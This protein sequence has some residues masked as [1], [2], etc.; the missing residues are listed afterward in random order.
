VRLSSVTTSF[1]ALGN[2][3]KVAKEHY[4]RVT[5]GD[6]AREAGQGEAPEEYAQHCSEPAVENS[7]KAFEI[8]GLEQVAATVSK[9]LQDYQVPRKEPSS[10]PYSLRFRLAISF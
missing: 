3:P 2:S 1:L 10:K 5:E 8:D 7:P 4:L 6:F 9:A